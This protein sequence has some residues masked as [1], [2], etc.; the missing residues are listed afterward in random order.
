MTAEKLAHVALMAAEFARSMNIEP[1]VA[2]LS[3]SNFGSVKHPLATIVREATEMVRTAAPDLQV[4]GEMH[5]DTA[6]VAEILKEDYPFCALE[7]PAN[8]LV[9][10][11]M[12]SG[13]ISY[14]LL[15]RLGGAR[16]IGPVILG[17]NDPAYVMQRHASVDEIFN[18]ITIA[19]AQAALKV[20]KPLTLAR[21]SGMVSNL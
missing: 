1:R 8:V 6:T 18:M 9:F 16:V 17:L 2:M 5:A 11:D 10:P 14:K 13:N 3:F 21:P 15:Q 19:V 4:D 7:G 12:Q 20:R